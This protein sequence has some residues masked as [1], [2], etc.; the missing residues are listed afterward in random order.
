MNVYINGFWSGFVE[1]T[2]GVHWGF[3]ETILTNVF[4]TNIEIT[5][6]MDKADILLETHFGNSLLDNKQWK[7]S[8]FF[9][10]E[11]VKSRALPDNIEMYTFCMGSQKT[12]T[13][14]ISCP[15]YVLYEY[16][17]PANCP[18]S[19][20]EIPPKSICSIISS[21]IPESYRYNFLDILREN[22][23]LY[24]SAGNYH[25]TVGFNIEGEYY[26]KP[27]IEFQKQ[28]RLVLA[29]E[30]AILDNYITEKIVNPFRA[31]TI[32][33]YLGSNKI[34]TY[35]NSERF[36]I[37]DINNIHNTINE[38]QKLLTDDKYWLEKVNQPIFKKSIL[39][40][41]NEIVLSMKSMKS[42]LN[43]RPYNVEII[44]N[45]SI[46][47]ER[48]NTLQ[49][50]LDYFNVTPTYTV[51]GEEAKSHKLYDKFYDETNINA[52]SLAI[53]HVSLLEKYKN[54][55]KFLLIY[56]SDAKPLY[57]LDTI[58][59]DI[60]NTI[61]EMKTNKIDFVFLGKG[62]FNHI[63]INDNSNGLTKITNTLYK[64][65]NSRCTESYLVSPDGINKF[66]DFFM[67]NDMHTVIDFTY[68]Y[69]FKHTGTISCWK[70]PELFYQDAN[71]SRIPNSQLPDK[72]R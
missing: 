4:D 18:S 5:N 3:F 70:I 63:D 1:K 22:D 30:N 53:N 71:I 33:V 28:Y 56:E 20:T 26:H 31:G 60:I 59:K 15:L 9:S 55:N 8:I 36:I 41:M 67:N 48:I 38:I 43:I 37:V 29:L 6:T 61:E 58:D 72:Y 45:L 47:N 46:E 66:L 2:N 16:C 7:Y 13:N 14:F 35:F 21:Y 42:I 39:E 40:I 50:L 32:P 19:I 10:G 52:I 65:Q 34:D 25:N 23:I 68:N 49:P 17:K 11:G 12:N 27:I 57:N 62:C 64:S 54:E 69:F 51:W 44:G 24:D